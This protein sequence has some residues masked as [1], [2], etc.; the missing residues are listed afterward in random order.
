MKMKELEART[1]VGRET[2]RYYIREGLLDEPERPKRNVAVYDESHVRRIALIKR[3]QHERFLPLAKIKDLLEDGAEELDADQLPSLL[4]LEFLLS[5]RFGDEQSRQP[6]PL[7]EV[8]ET[9]DV[10]LKEIEEM[11]QSGF[12]TIAAG[13]TLSKQDAGLVALWG[14]MRRAGYGK[15]QGYEIGTFARFVETANE[16]A[17]RDVEIFLSNLPANTSIAAATQMAET[18]IVL[19]NDMLGRLRLRA[20]IRELSR[21]NAR[22]VQRTSSGD[23]SSDDGQSASTTSG[24]KKKA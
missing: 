1:G 24:E 14:Q 22:A 2:I 17:A 10:P 7:S 11:D 4:G 16:L 20:I 21:I 9:T 8:A 19:T 3:L 5:A 18:G 6:V 13:G 12:V 15:E 23:K